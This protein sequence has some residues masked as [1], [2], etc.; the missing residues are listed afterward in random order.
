M[1]HH[2]DAV[3]VFAAMMRLLP[4]HGLT[5]RTKGKSS[6]VDAPPPE[7]EVST[8]HPLRL[9]ILP[10]AIFLRHQDPSADPFANDLAGLLP[11]FSGTNNWTIG[12][13]A[14]FLALGV[15]LYR[16]PLQ[17]PRWLDVS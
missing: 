5:A 15:L 2:A 8:S 1:S 12:Q 6:E 4:R 10:A 14:R 11:V 16:S 3:L 9:A 13:A 17:Q 7:R